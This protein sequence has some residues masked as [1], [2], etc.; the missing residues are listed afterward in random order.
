M[1]GRPGSDGGGISRL[2]D[3]K[4]LITHGS[5][6]DDHK[7]KGH[8]GQERRRISRG[9]ST[10]CMAPRT[11]LRPEPGTPRRARI[12]ELCNSTNKLCSAKHNNGTVARATTHSIR[13]YTALK[14]KN[15]W[16]GTCAK[17]RKGHRY[18]CMRVLK[19]GSRRSS[20]CK[21][22]DRNFGAV[23]IA[24]RK[25]A[26]GVWEEEKSVVG[27]NPPIADA[28]AALPPP[29]DHIREKKKDEEVRGGKWW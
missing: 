16:R 27:E 9:S 22:G 17:T 7:N 13:M 21:P 15:V 25:R 3:V 19:D 1:R 26:S 20:R 6:S 11:Q 18:K 10:R 29:R 8:H 14:S 24:A 12:M 4:I 23:A 2:Y 5:A 28:F